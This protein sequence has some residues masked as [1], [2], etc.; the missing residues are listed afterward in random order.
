MALRR[1]NISHMHR[2]EESRLN[3]GR[4]LL[5]FSVLNFIFLPTLYGQSKAPVKTLEKNAI[6]W[7]NSG[8]TQ[9]NTV[10]N[11]VIDL[12]D[13][14]EKSQI[15]LLQSGF[16]AFSAFEIKVKDTGESLG[17]IACSVR[18]DTWN[19][20]YEMIEV[21]VK[22]KQSTTKKLS[23]LAEVCFHVEIPISKFDKLKNTDPQSLLEIT[24][25]IEQISAEKSAEIKNWLVKQQSSILQGLFSH[26]LGELKLSERVY[27]QSAI[28][29][30]LGNL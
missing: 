12:S 15:E 14:L 20:R 3:I 21:G 28:P 6:F 13:L 7:S 29:K 25:S 5:F 27:F 26:M 8:D 30:R 11:L 16:S 10:K 9:K 4:A 22:P 1:A 24:L 17:R 23:R 18:Y 2:E 19:D